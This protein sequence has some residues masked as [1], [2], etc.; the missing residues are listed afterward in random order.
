MDECIAGWIDELLPAA[1]CLLARMPG[2]VGLPVLVA[3]TV[4]E[5]VGLLLGY[6]DLWRVAIKFFFVSKLDK[7]SFEN[8]FSVISD[9][10][11][12]YQL[13]I[14]RLIFTENFHCSELLH[15]WESEWKRQRQQQQ[16]MCWP[17]PGAAARFKK[18]QIA[19]TKK[20]PLDFSTLASSSTNRH[21]IPPCDCFG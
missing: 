12:S 19:K 18:E 21:L 14:F 2:K 4:N 3:R 6:D 7:S 13:S 11:S 15:V 5:L 16:V 9:T 20:I 17:L 1:S 8:G 10:L